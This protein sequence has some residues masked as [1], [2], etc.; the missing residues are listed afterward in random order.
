MTLSL[1]TTHFTHRHFDTHRRHSDHTDILADTRH[2]KVRDTSW[3]Y[4]TSTLEGETSYTLTETHC[5]HTFTRYH[6]E[7][8]DADSRWVP[9]L[10]LI[11]C[12]TQTHW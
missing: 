10:T 2:S 1:R 7:Y 11:H 8:L 5:T 3:H 9:H 12:E 4:D 6:Y